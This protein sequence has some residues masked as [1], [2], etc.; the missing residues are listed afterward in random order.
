MFADRCFDPTTSLLAFDLF[1]LD[2]ILGDKFL[3]NGVI[4]PVLHI[5]PRRYRFRWLNSAPS[6]FY[7]TTL[8]I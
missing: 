4:Q 2:G 5:H 7:K 3:V 8:P 6:Q 1:N